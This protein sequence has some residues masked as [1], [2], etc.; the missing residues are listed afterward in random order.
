MSLPT[1]RLPIATPLDAEAQRREA[2][3][4]GDTVALDVLLSDA[5]V[6]VHS[7]AARDDKAS[8]LAKLSNGSLRYLSL[9]FE[10]MQC[11]SMGECAV[12]TGRMLAQISKEGQSKHVRS[13][14]MTVWALQAHADG[15]ARTW[16]LCAHQGTP[17][18]V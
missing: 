2:L 17:A 14:F 10:D 12:V 8:Y 13:L 3:L 5:L 16:R 9:V 6:Y 11:H 7:N 15:Q 1:H 18:P 4:A